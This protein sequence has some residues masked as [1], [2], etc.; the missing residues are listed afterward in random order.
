MKSLH[1]RTV[2]P[3]LGLG[4]ALATASTTTAQRRPNILFLLADD[5]RAD[6]VTAFGGRNAHTPN[7]DALAARGTKLD[8]I[9]CMGSRHGAVCA[10]SRAMLMSGRYL[11]RVTDDLREVVTLPERLRAAGYATFMTGKWHNGEAA[12]TRAFPDASAVFRGGM[13]S[14]FDVPLCDVAAGRIVR[15]RRAQRASSE[16]FADTAIE[17]L[18]AQRRASAMQPFFVYL[19]FTA[20]HD[21]RDPPPRWLE[22]LGDLP[23]PALPANFRGQHGLD[24]GSAT[25]TVRDE[26]LL[27][28]PRDP[29]LLREQLVEYRALVAHLDEQVGRLLAALREEGFAD[30]TLVVFTSDHGLALGSHGLLGKQ[31]LYEHSMRSPCILAGRG[32]PRGASRS[33]L[34]YLLDLTATL[35]ATAGV[36][37]TGD[38]DGRN[39][40][41]LVHSQAPVRDDLVLIYAKTQRALITDR[42][43]LLRLPDIDCSLV[44]DLE[45][46]PHEVADLGGQPASMDLQASLT[47]RL[48]RA[49]LELSDPLPWTAAKLRPAEIDLSGRRFDPD[50]WQPDWIRNKYWTR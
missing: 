42:H 46:D 47:R 39:L 10:P 44:F 34:C 35:L 30:D 3:L 33:G 49:L 12:L 4:L 27:G 14:H 28:W 7:F 15:E 18:R 2:A 8:R 5:L 24:L 17:Y 13:C 22:R 40:W 29:D 25:M 1:L 31:S 16:V 38:I 37:E 9:Y 21:P 6:A 45:D 50:R 11:P 32:V 41:P 23:R 19:P 26:N 20:P 43:K 36:H 48:Q